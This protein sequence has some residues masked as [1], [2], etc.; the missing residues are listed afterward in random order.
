MSN[1]C[2]GDK[3]CFE[4][5]L[6]DNQPVPLGLLPK[7]LISLAFKVSKKE[8]YEQYRRGIA[9]HRENTPS[10]FS[11]PDDFDRWEQRLVAYFPD[12]PQLVIP[13]RRT[14]ILTQSMQRSQ[15]QP[16]KTKGSR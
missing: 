1:N 12:K 6:R 13:W 16:Q 8:R 9:E 15:G 5:Y 7:N 11:T 14:Q 2:S 4:S 10:G 3:E